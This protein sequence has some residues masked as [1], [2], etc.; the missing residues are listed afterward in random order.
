M[1]IRLYYD[2]K[3]ALPVPGA[4]KDVV[5]SLTYAGD[6]AEAVILAMKT[7]GRENQISEAGDF[8]SP[9]SLDGGHAV[10]T[11]SGSN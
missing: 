8:L 7:P 9:S 1:W 4:I 5:Q 3:K 11:Y 2:L 6:A 10:P